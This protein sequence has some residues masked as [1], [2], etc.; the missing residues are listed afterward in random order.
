MNMMAPTALFEGHRVRMMWERPVGIWR[1]KPLV[2]LRTMMPFYVFT[3]YMRGL[4]TPARICISGDRDRPVLLDDP[5]AFDG[6]TFYHGPYAMAAN[7]DEKINEFSLSNLFGLLY[8]WA[9]RD[10]FISDPSNEQTINNYLDI[11]HEWILDEL[12]RD[13]MNG[14][15]S[16]IPRM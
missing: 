13:H 16:K 10:G 7:F 15:G 4:E 6:G 8:N 2:L 5:L 12:Q 1:Y 9:T 3:A 14:A 11:F